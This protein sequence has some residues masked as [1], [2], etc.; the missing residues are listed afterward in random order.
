MLGYQNA[1]W[2]FL[3]NSEASLLEGERILDLGPAAKP[4][5]LTT[6]TVQHYS[7]LDQYLMGLR[8][9][10]AVPEN[11]FLVAG[12]SPFLQQLHPASGVAI[13]GTRRDIAVDEVV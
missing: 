7:P 11:L 2:S 5:F 3:F 9:P 12:A 10:G 8:P 6:D 1:H 4:R 13:D